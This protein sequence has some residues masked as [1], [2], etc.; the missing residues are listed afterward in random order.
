MKSLRNKV[1]AD[2]LRAQIMRDGE[3]AELVQELNHP[4]AAAETVTVETDVAIPV[5]IPLD[6]PAVP[7]PAVVPEV[8]SEPVLEP[9][10]IPTPA[11]VKVTQTRKSAEIPDPEV[12][13]LVAVATITG[14]VERTEAVT[15]QTAE[16]AETQ[17]PVLVAEPRTISEYA[18]W[19]RQTGRARVLI[20]E[21]TIYGDYSLSE[22]RDILPKLKG[23]LAGI[24]IDETVNQRFVDVSAE[25]GMKFI[26]AKSFE[27]IVH[28]PVSI[29]MIPL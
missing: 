10:Q 7:V 28:R 14:L 6:E 5:P 4:D 13:P 26:V 19:M 11:P 3:I 24:I 18:D 25:K 21:G 27:G 16:A 17:Q 8:V 23:D 20:G 1:P 2:V 22:I 9:V 29:R 15:P 12:P